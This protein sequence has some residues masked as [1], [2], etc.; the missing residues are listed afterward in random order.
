MSSNPNKPKDWSLGSRKK[1]CTCFRAISPSF[2]HLILS[3]STF[4]VA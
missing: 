1:A 3:L 2:E 4:S